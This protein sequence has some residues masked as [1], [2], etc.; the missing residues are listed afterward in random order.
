MAPQLL[1]HF[2][3]THPV[4]FGQLVNFDETFK[5]KNKQTNKKQKNKK[6]NKQTNKQT[7]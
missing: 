1:L 7:N 2:F 4:L 6:K 5:K 3:L